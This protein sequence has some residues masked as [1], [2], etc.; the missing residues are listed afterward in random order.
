MHGDTGKTAVVQGALLAAMAVAVILTG[1]GYWTS[2]L[3]QEKGDLAANALQVERAREGRELLG[4]YSRWE[5]HH[6]GPA[7]FYLQAWTEPLFRFLPSLLGR[8]QAA[9]LL[10]NLSLVGWTLALLRRAGLPPPPLISGCFLLVL[11]L[12]FLGG[13]HALMLAGV[14]GPLMV[15][16]PVVLF[17]TAAARLW[18]GDLTALPAAALAGTLAYQSHLLTLPVIIVLGIPVAVLLVARPG[19]F[20]PSPGSGR[21][22][23]LMLTAAAIAGVGL[24]PVIV[25]E[26]RGNP[27]NLTLLWR[28][29]RESSPTVHP[30]SEVIAVLGQAVT[31]PLVVIWPSAAG[32]WTSP[33][34]TLVLA[35]GFA[36]VSGFQYRKSGAGWRWVLVA[37][38][39]AIAVTVVVARTVHGELHTYM[40]YYLYGLVGLLDVVVAGEAL[41]RLRDGTG[42]R[43]ALAITGLVMLVPWLLAHTVEPP[44]GDDGFSTLMDS[45]DLA[46]GAEIHL[47]LGDGPEDNELWPRIPTYA[48]RLR[49]AG[50][51]VRLPDR[52]VIMCGEEMR[53]ESSKGQAPTLLFTREGDKEGVQ[54][55]GLDPNPKRR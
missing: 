7:G 28:F 8:H 18:A 29:L 39:I 22:R 16:F 1:L 26:I 5:F 27:G 31:D 20:A 40:F 3:L 38:W 4:P 43:A 21:G 13:G 25:E 35:A 30:W 42:I 34:V 14:W 45:L 32:F 53:M 46:P 19:R 36:A 10:L 2:P 6:P 9:Q 12:I 11:P 17:V 48:L 15:V 50:F 23:L 33:G 51:R 24:V 44:T 54:V 47:A 37:V 55:V 49:R 41:A 52:F